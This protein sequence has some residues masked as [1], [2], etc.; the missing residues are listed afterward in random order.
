MFITQLVTIAVVHL[1]AVMTPGPDFAM[2]TRNSLIYSRRIGVCT[3]FGIALGILVHTAYSLLG[4]GLLI[5]KSIVLFNVIK[6]VGA[7]YL[8]YIGWKSLRAKPQS[9]DSSAELQKEKQISVAAAI[10]TGFLTNVLNPKA[11]LFFLALF[12]QVIDPATPKLIQ[13]FYGFEMMVITFAWFGFLSIVFSNS[14]IKTKI[15]RFQH[16]IEQMTGVVLLALGIKV[17]LSSHK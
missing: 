11:T 1:L 6:F 5:S 9:A 14:I 7:G 10:K 13:S 3:S 15:T 8:I 16:R 12:T 2:V 17:A 4:I